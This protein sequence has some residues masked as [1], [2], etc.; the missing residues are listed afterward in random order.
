[1][2]LVSCLLWLCLVQR[3][4]DCCWGLA[5]DGDKAFARHDCETLLCP[6]QVLGLAPL[7]LLHSKNQVIKPDTSYG[8]DLPQ[9]S[10]PPPTVLTPGR[11]RLP[12]HPHTCCLWLSAAQTSTFSFSFIVEVISC[13]NQSIDSPICEHWGILRLSLQRAF[14]RFVTNN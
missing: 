6:L 10:C 5:H 9:M 13:C 11:S 3:A 4:R 1:M 8:T 7:L 12:G 2:E 14:V